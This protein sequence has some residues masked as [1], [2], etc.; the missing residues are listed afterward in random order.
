[1]AMGTL[2][3]R[4]AKLEQARQESRSRCIDEIP[5]RELEAIVLDGAK[6]LCGGL[7]IDPATVDDWPIEAACEFVLAHAENCTGSAP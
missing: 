2:E 4:I 5:D 3:N 7:G 6:A 1:M